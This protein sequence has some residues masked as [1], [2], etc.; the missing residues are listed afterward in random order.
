[1]KFCTQDF[2]LNDLSRLGRSIEIDN[3]LMKT[4]LENNLIQCGRKSIDL[5]YLKQAPKVIFYSFCY[6]SFFDVWIS[7]RLNEKIHS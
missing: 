1:M 5:E 2:L 6:V 3:G 7:Q 4:L